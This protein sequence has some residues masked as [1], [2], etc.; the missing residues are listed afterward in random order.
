MRQ[1]STRLIL[2]LTATNSFRIWS[3]DVK[4][5]YLQSSEKLMRK[6]YL[7]PSKSFG[8]PQNALLELHKTLYGEADSKDYWHNTMSRYLKEDLKMK[9]CTDEMSLFYKHL[10]DDLGG[11]TG[12]HVDD[13][14]SAGT[15]Q[16]GA[17][18]E[19]TMERFESREKVKDNNNFTG[20]NIRAT[21]EGFKL[22]Q[23]D[24][25]EKLKPLLKYCTFSDFMSKRAQLSWI[26]HTRPEIC[27]AVNMAA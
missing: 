1:S 22:D 20:V 24:Y 25:I 27:C 21:E 9:P 19:K 5:A 15:S 10:N 11:M 18:T 8:L 23:K 16:F 14:I 2:A 17:L 6:V 7:K 3:Q 13:S 4:Q 12:T 26:S